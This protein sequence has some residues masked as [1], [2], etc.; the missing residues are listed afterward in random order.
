MVAKHALRYLNG[1]IDEGITYNGNLG[2]KL[3]FWSDAKWGGEEGRE[4]VS[5]FVATICKDAVKAVTK[6]V[7]NG[8]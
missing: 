3:E 5:G 7:I 4:S 1:T 2:M 8:T 6:A